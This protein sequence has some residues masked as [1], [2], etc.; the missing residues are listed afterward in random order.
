MEIQI[1]II[2]KF[3]E[4][5]GEIL[6]V[7]QEQY[8]TLTTMSSEYYKEGFEMMCEDGSFLVIPPELIKK[9]IYKINHV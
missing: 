5:K 2:N 9:S 1:V 3:G 6:N 4:F 7:T 8:E